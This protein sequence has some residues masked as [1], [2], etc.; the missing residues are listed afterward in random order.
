MLTL[1]PMENVL[2][3]YTKM[4][5]SQTSAM[6]L[7][8]KITAHIYPQALLK[9]S[10]S[11]IRSRR[12]NMLQTND[13]RWTNRHCSLFIL[14]CYDYWYSQ[15]AIIW[16]KNTKKTVCVVWYTIFHKIL[17]GHLAIFWT[18]LNYTILLH[19]IRGYS[20][21]VRLKQSSKLL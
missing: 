18:I 17:C 12:E 20:F 9:W 11:Q 8:L 6:T 16:K 2:V 21:L 4:G 15:M 19:T 7:T 13:V 14:A 3:D 1:P 5:F 10:T